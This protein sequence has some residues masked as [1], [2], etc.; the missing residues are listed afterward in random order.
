MRERI[1]EL[2]VREA[3]LNSALKDA[4]SHLGKAREATRLAEDLFQTRETELI[5]EIRRRLSAIESINSEAL[6][7]EIE[8]AEALA[9]IELVEA[10]YAEKKRSAFSRIAK[11][12]DFMATY[13]PE[14]AFTDYD[15]TAM[16][17]SEKIIEAVD[18]VEE[19]KKEVSSLKAKL[20]K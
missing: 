15:E 20:E 5:G 10:E 4:R 18:Q 6:E 13:D 8:L 14:W 7:K 19:L 1:D 11:L 16:M 3:E 9:T 17:L 2:E 12:K